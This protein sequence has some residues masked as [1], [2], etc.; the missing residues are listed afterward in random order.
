MLL[1]CGAAG[2]KRLRNRCEPLP[3][4]LPCPDLIACGRRLAVLDNTAHAVWTGDRIIPVDSGVEAMLLWRNSLLT[5]S[6]DTDC[7][8]RYA[9]PTGDRLITVPAGVYPQDMCLL[10]GGRS[11]AVCGG[12]DGLLH[13][14]RLPDLWE[15]QAIPLPGSVQRVACAPSG[16]YAL[17]AL[18]DDGLCCQLMRVCCRS[19]MA[20]ARWHGLPGAL[21]PDAAGRLW[22][23]ASEMLCC[24]HPGGYTT[25][26]GDYGL[27]THMD[28]TGLGLL[29]TDPVLE[30]C[31]LVQG[32]GPSRAIYQGM[33]QHAVFMR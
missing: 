11:L 28:C 4:P 14:I 32:S 29:L 33:V 9:L 7:L 6:G 19:A 5:L 21:C 27:I 2:L 26:P 10:P 20:L 13:I 3:C 24:L 18:E 31:L 8:T 22:I 12:A 23:A 15:E 30:Q 16:I 25:L 1:A 17:C